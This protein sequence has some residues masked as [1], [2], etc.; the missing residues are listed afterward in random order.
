MIKVIMLGDAGV[1]KT[2]F[3]IRFLDGKFDPNTKMT[4][5]PEIL[6]HIIDIENEK[7][8]LEIWDIGGV[9]RFR[10]LI[11]DFCNNL[12][13][14]ILMFDLT[15]LST[16]DHL[17]DWVNFVRNDNPDAP[18]LLV[19]S[20]LDLVNDIEV[21]DDYAISFLEPLNL[22]GYIKIS[23]KSGENIN[24]VFNELSKSNL[25]VMEI[26]QASS[27]NEDLENKKYKK[28]IRSVIFEAIY[29]KKH[30][31]EIV[32]RAEEIFNE[33]RFEIKIK[34]IIQEVKR[35]V[36]EGLLRFNFRFGWRY[37]SFEEED[38]FDKTEEIY[39]KQLKEVENEFS[40]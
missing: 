36:D 38:F 23:A 19:G 35:L 30:L 40:D 1:G 11:P 37:G 32:K 13:G 27:I 4:V 20:K 21:K 7:I 6:A 2:T 16:L 24:K 31:K 29:K 9:S 17:E 5:G 14:A 15:R 34:E 39:E 3:L 25:K 26:N 12:D 22:S 8:P 33:Y 28:A 18:I 10:F